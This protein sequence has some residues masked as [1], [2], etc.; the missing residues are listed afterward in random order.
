MS[1]YVS[2]PVGAPAGCFNTSKMKVLIRGGTSDS[3]EKIFDDFM[4]VSAGDLTFM[5][6][7]NSLDADPALRDIYFHNESKTII[8]IK[9][10]WSKT[11]S[12]EHKMMQSGSSSTVTELLIRVEV[13]NPCQLSS[14][15]IKSTV[16]TATHLVKDTL[17]S[18]EWIALG[19]ISSLTRICGP[20]TSD[21]SITQVVDTNNAGIILWGIPV[22]NET[23]IIVQTKSE[24]DLTLSNEG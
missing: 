9:F 5:V 14:S 10:S 1:D 21:T 3:S 4:T 6:P 22:V 19:G 24:A 2:A 23:S 18:Y 7:N 11:S 16:G 20:I 15:F 13:K 12:G 17:N 8:T